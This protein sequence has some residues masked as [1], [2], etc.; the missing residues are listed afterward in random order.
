L[1]LETQAFHV[2]DAAVFAD[3]HG[4]LQRGAERVAGGPEP[5]HVLHE[6]EGAGPRYVA[7]ERRRVD[8][9]GEGLPS[10]RRALEIDLDLEAGAVIGLE[11]GPGSAAVDAHRLDDADV[12]AL[13]VERLDAGLVDGFDELGSAAVEDRHLVAIDL[14]DDVVD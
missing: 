2:D 12:A 6:T 11:F 10:D 14:D 9:G 3:H 5:L 13:D 4:I 8:V 1:V 7:A